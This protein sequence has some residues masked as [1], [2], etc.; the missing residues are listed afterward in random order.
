MVEGE[1]DWVGGQK[2]G[3]VGGGG[4]GG[5]GGK[6]VERYWTERW[7]QLNRQRSEHWTRVRKNNGLSRSLTFSVNLACLQREGKI[8]T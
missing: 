5:E 3:W 6:S 2:S 4:G 7:L 8:K 1:E